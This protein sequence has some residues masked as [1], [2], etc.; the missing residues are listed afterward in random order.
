M[1]FHNL[2]SNEDKYLFDENPFVQIIVKNV[3]SLNLL[4]ARVTN[5]DKG[6]FIKV[7]YALRAK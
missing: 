6:F 5:K 4:L 7:S 3:S 1:A 2:L